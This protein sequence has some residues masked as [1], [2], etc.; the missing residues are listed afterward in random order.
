MVSLYFVEEKIVWLLRRLCRR[1]DR[2]NIF[3]DCSEN[4]SVAHIPVTFLVVD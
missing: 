4:Q 3:D 2:A 1:K